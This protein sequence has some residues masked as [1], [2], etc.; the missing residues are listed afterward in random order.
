MKYTSKITSLFASEILDSRGNP[1]VEVV[2]ELDGVSASASVPSDLLNLRLEDLHVIRTA[3]E[4]L[5]RGTDK[6]F[7]ELW[8]S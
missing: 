2:I 1:T 3:T 7:K 5:L 8:S 4:I 6:Q